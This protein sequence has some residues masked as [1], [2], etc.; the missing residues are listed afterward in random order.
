MWGDKNKKIKNNR[1]L[2]FT[3]S[4]EVCSWAVAAVSH[5]VEKPQGLFMQ[6]RALLS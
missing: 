2:P 6:P 1:Y 3:L 4:I 5:R